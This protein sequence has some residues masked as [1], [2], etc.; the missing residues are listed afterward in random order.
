M[1]SSRGLN[2][3]YGGYRVSGLN[4]LAKALL[5]GRRRRAPAWLRDLERCKHV[6]ADANV[7][8]GCTT[9]PSGCLVAVDESVGARR[10]IPFCSVPHL[11]HDGH[12]PR[13]PS[14]I[15]ENEYEN[16]EGKELK[17]N[18]QRRRITRFSVCLHVSASPCAS[19]HL[20]T[21]SACMHVSA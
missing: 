5:S 2:R 6:H 1:R 15:H 18:E 17:R 21:V 7:R 9:V 13:T 3:D 8:N 19:M 20:E 14:S 4:N 16:V 12:W 11:S 10:Q